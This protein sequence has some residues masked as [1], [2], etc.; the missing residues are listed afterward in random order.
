[1]T[2]QICFEAHE[3]TRLHGRIGI[4]RVGQLSGDTKHGIWNTS[5]AWPM[6]LSSVKL[7]GALPDLQNEPLSWLPVDTAAEAL[8][9][10][11]DS[12]NG[13]DDINVF[14]IVN[15]HQTPQWADLLGWL[16][17]NESFETLSPQEWVRK[18]EKVEGSDAN[19]P[20]MKLL[21]HWQKLYGDGSV[22]DGQPQ[23]PVEF[24]MRKTKEACEMM[25]NVAPLDEAYFA[26]IREWLDDSM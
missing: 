9:Q 5:E 3:T 23:K 16:K 6:M 21:G 10:G 13:G 12:L 8:V 17:K 15:E 7:T 4:F 14:H 22:E 25:R 2:E 19:H 26:K 20:A 1:V 11:T 18:L 24:D